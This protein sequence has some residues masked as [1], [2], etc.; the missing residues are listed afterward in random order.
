MSPAAILVSL[1]LAILTAAYLAA[2]FRRRATEPLATSIERWVRHAPVST[3]VVTPV[4][5]PDATPAS[6]DARYCRHCGRQLEPDSRF[7]AGCG[8]PVG[9]GSQ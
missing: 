6:S 4:V 2:P 8:Q 9:G 3:S 5:A 7:C 1:S